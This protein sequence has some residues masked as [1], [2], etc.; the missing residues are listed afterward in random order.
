[1]KLKIKN[2]LM[3][4]PLSFLLLFMFLLGFGQTKEDSLFIKKIEKLISSKQMNEFCK[5]YSMA[6]G[7]YDATFVYTLKKNKNI[8]VFIK[9]L[10]EHKI[11]YRFY[12]GEEDRLE[13][14]NVKIY[15]KNWDKNDYIVEGEQISRDYKGEIIEKKFLNDYNLDKK[16]IEKIITQQ[17]KQ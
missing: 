9:I 2:N 7:N 12:S 11:H 16:E 3:K 13:F 6:P 14:F 17:N 1:L 4:T 8:P 15:V 10:V 5:C